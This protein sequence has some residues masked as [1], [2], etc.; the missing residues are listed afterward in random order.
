ML[1]DVVADER[2]GGV[3]F[4]LQG[5]DFRPCRGELA[6]CLRQLLF[7]RGDMVPLPGSVAALVLAH[8]V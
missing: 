1:G 4:R 2:I 6:F 3:A 7:E 8:A 5:F